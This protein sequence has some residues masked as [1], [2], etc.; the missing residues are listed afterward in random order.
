M[1]ALRRAWEIFW[2][3]YSENRSGWMIHKRGGY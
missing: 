2:K 1:T 3:A